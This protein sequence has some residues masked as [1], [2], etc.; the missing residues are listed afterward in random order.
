MLRALSGRN[1]KSWSFFG[2]SV[3]LKVVFARFLSNKSSSEPSIEQRMILFAKEWLMRT[4]FAT[5]AMS[6]LHPRNWS[7][8]LRRNASW[9]LNFLVGL[10]GSSRMLARTSAKAALAAS[11]FSLLTETMPTKIRNSLE[12]I[13]H[14][15]NLFYSM[16]FVCLRKCYFSEPPINLHHSAYEIGHWVIQKKVSRKLEPLCRIL[17]RRS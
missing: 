3:L 14:I 17:I 8:L 6:P 11:C 10:P 2:H 9:T 16:F 12:V 4:S 1:A 15:R 5:I 7:C 13:Q